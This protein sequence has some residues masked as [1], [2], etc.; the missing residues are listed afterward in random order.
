MMESK[1]H[2]DLKKKAEKWLKKE[3][4]FEPEEIFEEYQ[5]GPYWIDVVGRNGRKSVAV[6]CGK[7]TGSSDH[8]QKKIEYLEKEFDC[9]KRL[10]FIHT[11]YDRS[12]KPDQVEK[13]LN[14]EAI[15]AIQVEELAKRD[16]KV[17]RR[18][19]SLQH[20]IP[21]DWSEVVGLKAGQRTVSTLNYDEERGLHIAIWPKGEEPIE[22]SNG[23]NF[24]SIIAKN[25]S[26]DTKILIREL[27]RTEVHELVDKL[28]DE[29]LHREKDGEIIKDP[30]TKLER[31]FGQTK[32]ELAEA[33][34]GE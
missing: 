15:T 30:E 12:E 3:H 17:Q 5:S 34:R 27:G 9:Y 31:E 10:G 23:K 20:T 16:M 2:K 28:A 18:S 19:S 8:K 21:S 13:L 1:A 6:E 32:E 11:E 14:K 4:G 24:P 25:F 7:I 33:L 29:I 26:R 22:D